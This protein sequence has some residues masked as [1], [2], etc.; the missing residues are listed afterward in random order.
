MVIFIFWQH[1]WRKGMAAT[2]GGLL[3]CVVVLSLFWPEV[4]KFISGWVPEGWLAYVEPY[5]SPWGQ[6]HVPAGF[7]YLP[8]SAWIGDFETL[9]WQGI[10]AFAEAINFNLVPFLAVAGTLFFWPRHRGWESVQHKRLSFILLFT[11]LVMAGMHTWVALSGRSCQFFCLAGYFTFFNFIALL[12]LPAAAYSW[13]GHIPGWR[14]LLSMGVIFGIVYGA[15]YTGG[16]TQG[17][18][19]EQWYKLMHTEIPRISGGK[20]LWDER[21]LLLSL[22]EAKLKLDY[23]L[24]VEVLPKYVYW[25][26]LILLVFAIVPLF[27]R[28]KWRTVRAPYSVA[29]LTIVALLVAGVVLS[30]TPILRYD[31]P[32]LSCEDNVIDSHEEV[33]SQ[34]AEMIE[35]GSL[36]Y[37]DLTSNMLFLYLPE[38]EIFPPQLNINFSFIHPSNSADS[39]EIYRFG[40]WDEH[41]K[42]DWLAEAD[43]LLIPNQFAANWHDEL[44]SDE[45]QMV[46]EAGPYETCR[47]DRTLVY[48]LERVSADD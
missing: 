40:Y 43:V 11:W 33:G 15:L 30:P 26:L 25:I 22:F 9:Q 35:P 6:Q 42:Q 44:T 12:L 27:H 48:V 7:G 37:Q 5:R 8:L 21:G 36:V 1:G 24:L 16:Y 10:K 23:H 18:M 47:P 46:G 39:D 34:L 38:I 2:F 28:L 4:L 17:W 3:V 20:I 29:W 14:N 13:R 45:W 41:L 19:F 31:T 32:V